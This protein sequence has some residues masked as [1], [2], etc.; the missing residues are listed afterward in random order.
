MMSC[1]PVESLLAEREK[2]RVPGGRFVKRRLEAGELWGSIRCMHG[3]ASAGWLHVL[4][5]N[6]QRLLPCHAGLYFTSK[7]AKLLPLLL[8]SGAQAAGVPFI[9]SLAS[10]SFPLP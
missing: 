3:C 9:P 6:A 10:K 5:H 2:K 7:R 4:L 1:K 8:I